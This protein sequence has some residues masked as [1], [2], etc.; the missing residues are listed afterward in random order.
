ME[1][2]K[3]HN[4]TYDIGHYD[5]SEELRKELAKLLATFNQLK[6]SPAHKQYQANYQSAKESVIASLGDSSITDLTPSYQKILDKIGGKKYVGNEFL[7][8]IQS[9][10]KIEDFNTADVSANLKKLIDERNQFFDSIKQLNTSF[11]QLNIGYHYWTTNK[12]ELGILVPKKITDNHEIPDVTKHLNRWNRILKDVNEIIGQ[13]SDDIKITFQD[14]GSLHYFFDCPEVTVTAI[15][16]CIERLSA[17]YKKILEIRKLRSE[18]KKYDFPK[19]EQKSIEKHESTTIEKEINSIT[20]GLFKEQA[21]KRF[22]GGRRNELKNALKLHLKWIAKQM[23]DGE[24]VEVN[25]PK[26]AKPEKAE[27]ESESA[28]KKKISA[29]NKQQKKIDLLVS[30][31]NIAN[32]VVKGGEQIFKFLKSGEEE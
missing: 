6:S 17:L 19:K 30:K 4:L 26:L 5:D 22:E 20:E 24:I 18:L 13:G 8:A 25:P 9:T 29:I 23:D 14:I 31:V 28:H 32:D 15:V 11:K 27:N 7:E 3:L 16:T 2:T 10:L 12:L 21:K 1:V